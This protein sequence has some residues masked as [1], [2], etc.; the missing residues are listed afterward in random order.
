MK[1]YDEAV[2]LEPGDTNALLGRAKVWGMKKRYDKAIKDI[3]EAI[4]LDP[5]DPQV[6]KLRGWGWLHQRV[7]DKA[8]KDFDEAIRLSPKDAGG[9]LDRATAWRQ[10]KDFGK[11]LKDYAEARRLAP[12][13]PLGYLLSAS[14]LASCSDEKYRDGKKAVE[15]AK[16]ACEL[17]EWGRIQAIEVLAAAYAEAG[18]FDEAVRWQKKVLNDEEYAETQ[19]E[20]ARER[21]KL[22]EQKKP[23]R[24]EGD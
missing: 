3:D 11:A 12:K 18:L 22:Y 19:G 24:H 15:L 6:F 14:L 2:R 10:K 21:L 5:T 7:F 4:R 13:D 17:T 16:R 23:Y 8:V 20:Q 1:D 9:Y